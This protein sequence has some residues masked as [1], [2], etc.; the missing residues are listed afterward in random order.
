VIPQRIESDE[1]IGRE[2]AE[3]IE[4]LRVDLKASSSSES[5]VRE[6][7]PYG[8]VLIVDDMESNL[9]VAKG[10]LAPYGLGIDTAKSGQEAIDK[11]TDGNIY[12]MILMD[13][14]MPV[15]DGVDTTQ[16][17]REM[18]YVYPI[19]TLTANAMQ[20]QSDMFLSK[21]FDAFLSKPVDI[22]QLDLTLNRLIRD[23]Y[24]QEVIDEAR[25]MKQDIFKATS[26]EHGNA[27]PTDEF[28]QPVNALDTELARLFVR[29]GRKIADTLEVV[30]E[31]MGEPSEDDLTVYTSGV[32]AIKS[33]LANIGESDLSMTAFRLE[34]AGRRRDLYTI[35][36]ETG[37]FVAGL[38]AVIDK[39]RPDEEDVYAT[40]S[41]EDRV[42][43]GDKWF[44]V[45]AA[46][47]A[48]DKKESLGELEEISKKTWPAAI[49]EVVSAVTDLISSGNFEGAADMAERES[50]RA[51]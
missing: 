29:D 33:A 49:M 18:G 38:R 3:N 19:V 39:V 46:C 31:R 34:Q 7:M 9:Y 13:H 8:N 22:R 6:Y 10:L 24:P 28:D 30:Y 35:T 20:G 14:M 37:E 40:L 26:T 21:G 4:M 16:L 48:K 50:N 41:D 42:F 17:I 51:I 23:R 5:F 11:I 32:H 15:M 12:D 25:R 45:Y 1:V 43:L 47:I 2:M 27:L 36:T 44:A